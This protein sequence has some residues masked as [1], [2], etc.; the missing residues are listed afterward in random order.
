MLKFLYLFHRI[1]S[2]KATVPLPRCRGI[3]LANIDEAAV[4]PAKQRP[5]PVSEYRRSA[6]HRRSTS[7]RGPMMDS[8]TDSDDD[9][10]DGIRRGSDY[11]N[12]MD[13]DEPEDQS[14]VMATGITYEHPYA[15]ALDGR[16][17]AENSNS[18]GIQHINVSP[19]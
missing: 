2:D 10:D 1:T 7:H 11:D 5:P 6:S 14:V 15:W 17:S 19:K 18:V 16:L 3:R 9:D 4:T 13:I 8:D 12:D